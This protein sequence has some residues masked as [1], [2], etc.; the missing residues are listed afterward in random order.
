MQSDYA[1]PS[2]GSP[3]LIL[4]AVSRVVPSLRKRALHRKC[5]DG[6]T[7]LRSACYALEVRLSPGE[8]YV[9]EYTVH[10]ELGRGAFDGG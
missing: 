5:A 3:E 8:V 6:V 2:M 4:S 7:R 10:E 1:T 9:G